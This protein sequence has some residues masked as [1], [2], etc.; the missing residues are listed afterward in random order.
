MEPIVDLLKR[1]DARVVVTDFSPLRDD[2]QGVQFVSGRLPQ[3]TP[4]YQVGSTLM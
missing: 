4:L 3:D 2:L 1:L